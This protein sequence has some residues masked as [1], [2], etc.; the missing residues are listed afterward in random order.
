M[1]NE[2]VFRRHFGALCCAFA[3]VGCAGLSANKRSPA[4]VTNGQFTPTLPPVPSY[5][6]DPKLTCPTGGPSGAVADLVKKDEK[7]RK[8]VADGR[9]CAIAETLLGWTPPSENAPVPDT[10]RAFVSQYFGL[11]GIIQPN[12]II[13]QDM[14]RADQGP[15]DAAEPFVAPL[16]NFAENAVAPRY[17]V[18][19]DRYASQSTGRAGTG[20]TTVK[21]HVR[22]VMFDDVVQLDPPLPRSL[23]QGGS[24]TVSGHVEGTYKNLKLQVVDPVGKLTTTPLEGQK[25]SAPIACGDRPGKMLVQINGEGESGDSR[26]ANLPIDCGGQPA[27]QVALAA[28]QTGPIDPPQAEKEIA[29]SINQQRTTAGLKPLNVSV[30]LSD[31]ARSMSEHQVAGKPLSG[32]DLSKMIKEK[33]VSAG[34]INASGAMAFSSDEAA[35]KLSD[36]PSD[37]ANQM[38]P[39]VTD[40]GLGVAKGNEVGGKPTIMVSVLY[41]KTLP[42]ADPVAVKAKL[43]EAIGKKRADANLEALQKDD[44]LEGVAQAYADAAAKVPTGQVPR[45]QESDI[46]GPLYKH[47]MVVNQF[48]G[49]VP[50]EPNALL[51]VGDQPSVVGKSKLVGVGVALGKSDRFGKN[52]IFMMVLVGSH[53]TPQKAPAKKS[54][55]KK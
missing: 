8:L 18:I 23:P 35:A 4:Q 21:Y 31:I 37:R 33:E 45:D 41:V 40:L 39:E 53:S 30:P 13:A 14:E 16:L 9:L 19:I 10:L 28:P 48:G 49:W 55:K 11:P 7:G 42:P 2:G 27:T 15:T 1:M 3:M 24:A 6:P 36:N 5:G 51:Q 29:A 43:Y 32:G 22:V 25:F 46:L 26:L 54:T 12:R 47:A 20:Q 17:G 52:S 50:D 38:S 44:T 34:A